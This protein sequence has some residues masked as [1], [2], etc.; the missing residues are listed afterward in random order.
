MRDKKVDVQAL[1]CASSALLAV[2]SGAALGSVKN[3]LESN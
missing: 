2:F 3:T 1:F